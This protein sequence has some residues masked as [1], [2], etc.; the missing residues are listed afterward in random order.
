MILMALLYKYRKHRRVQ[1]I[2]IKFTPFPISPYTK[3]EKKRSSMGAG[4]LFWDER[5]P[6]EAA[7]AEKRQSQ[8]NYGSVLPPP[9]TQPSPTTAPLSQRR[10]GPPVLEI[11]LG[12]N[13]RPETPQGDRVVSPLSTGFPRTPSPTMPSPRSS[14]SS[15][16]ALSIA[17]SGVLSPSLFSWPMPPSTPGSMVSPPTSSHGQVSATADKTARYIPVPGRSPQ[18]AQPSNWQRPANWVG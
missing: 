5:D 9:V 8:P 10:E 12:K 7:M 16:G 3:S 17:S 6:N 4:L 11:A 13:S 15:V 14:V 2:L 18:P 1:T